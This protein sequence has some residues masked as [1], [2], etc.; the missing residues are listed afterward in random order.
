MRFPPSLLDEIRDRLPISEVVGRRVK[1]K[2]AGRGYSGLCPFHQE[3]SPSFTCDDARQTFKCFGCGK[4]GD[5]FGFVIETEGLPFPEAVERLAS[6]SGVALPK[7]DERSEARERKRSSLYEVMEQACRF[8]EEA[9]ASRAGEGARAYLRDRGIPAEATDEFRLG[10]APGWRN[11][12]R[13]HLAAKG[14]SAEEMIEAGLLVS[15]EDIPVAFDR[16]RDRVIFPI[17]DMRG[18]VVAFGGRAMSKD[19]PAK[20]LN[21]PETPLFHKGA[22]L[23]N[24]HRA[25]GPAHERGRIVAVEG[26]VDVIACHL[27]GIREAVAPL[28]T[29]L[30][31]EQLAQLWKFADEPILCF[32][33]DAAGLKA[34]NRAI[35]LALPLLAPGKSLAFALLPEGQ[36]PD[37]LVRNGGAAALEAA[38]QGT[39]PLVGRI[40]VRERDLQ[41]LDTPE[42]RAALEARIS[43]HV[44]A[45][46]H[47]GVRR[48]YADMLR[49]Q[50][51]Q[52]FA[53][54][55]EDRAEPAGR[56]IRAGRYG[57]GPARK[58]RLPAS[59]LVSES[60]RRTG[61]F[62]SAARPPRRREMIIVAVPA[63]HPAL[64]DQHSEDLSAVKLEDRELD[65]FRWSLL[66][67]AGA[68]DLSAAEIRARL[69]AL[70]FAD[71][72]ARLD[73]TMRDQRHW[74]A[75]PQ[76]A[77]ADAA[78][79]W[80]HILALHHKAQTLNEDL[81]EA[82]TA[83][84]QDQ[85]EANY[86]RLRSIL[87]ELS[88]LEGHEVEI[89]G[90]GSASGRPV[91]TF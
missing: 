35:D 61:L 78:T 4:G 76:A 25:R 46:R 1:L 83:L 13:E 29:A 28:G 20:Y 44:A 30:T 14:V 57:A 68:G 80:R 18:R 11:A 85:S 19:A 40:W 52:H 17:Q 26:Y 36:D 43:G 10:Y 50:L 55:R 58:A 2:R 90:L 53:G 38:L 60:A 7:A 33:G 87:S 22:M 42:R 41:P 39:E 3:R 27:A 37:D 89:E 5:I 72:I 59:R 9:L 51:R 81:Q 12:L 74:F 77:G 66:D 67:V 8:Y 16:F 62:S 24:A 21:S 34:A 88:G 71:L 48:H 49:Q 32:D 84:E 64:L 70:G 75:D 56:G 86:T 15:G 69:S 54:R 31:E 82:R 23:F 65:R 91:R 6:E 47:E 63:N 45:I 73:A 79:A